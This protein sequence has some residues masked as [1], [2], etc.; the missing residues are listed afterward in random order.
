[1]KK[2]E[3]KFVQGAPR[4]T[5]T[6]A[7]LPHLW[8]HAGVS[9]GYCGPGEAKHRVFDGHCTN[10]RIAGNSADRY[11]AP[12]DLAGSHWD[13]YSYSTVVARLFIEKSKD[14][15]DGGQFKGCK[16]L[17]VVS[18]QNHSMT[19]NK[20]QQ[21]IIRAIPVHSG[22][23]RSAA[24]PES[25]VYVVVV[26]CSNFDTRQKPLL[27]HMR[28]HAMHA[29]Q[30]VRELQ[31]SKP[32]KPAQLQK[33]LNEFHA[34]IEA[35]EVFQQFHGIKTKVAQDVEGWVTQKKKADRKTL[36]SQQKQNAAYAVASAKAA[37]AH[38]TA[39]RTHLG[40]RVFDW[41]ETLNDHEFLDV[42]L[43]EFERYAGKVPAR[44][45]KGVVI[46]LP[47]E[48]AVVQREYAA[49]LKLATADW[50]ERST[51]VHAAWR[52]R[53]SGSLSEVALEAES[54][55]ATQPPGRLPYDLLRAHTKGSKIVISTSRGTE[56][57]ATLS[58]AR[59]ILRSIDLLRAD[60]TL[61]L[62]VGPYTAE[63]VE[64][65]G[66]KV[67]CHIFS[68]AEAMIFEINLKE[69]LK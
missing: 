64:G 62:E 47:E 32:K 3:K 67:G 16:R 58:V 4:R 21:Q 68:G 19:T 13:I 15:T 56:F 57:I 18:E 11:A 38:L 31:E 53:A 42:N 5:W 6:S 35:L 17:Y 37:I 54:A 69:L 49:K 51:P 61:K 60:N 10:V 45:M 44:L 30:A 40:R 50:I 29:A 20:L 7:Q 55:F 39:M 26:P 2:Q 8:A 24:Y 23:W 43:R 65:G 1:M 27:D 36:A 28:V 59:G 52:A 22:N 34:R 66:F 9:G 14:I 25:G 41:R 33:A 48:V 46:P 12:D 63:C